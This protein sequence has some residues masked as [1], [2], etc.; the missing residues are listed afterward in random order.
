[1]KWWRTQFS[2]LTSSLVVVL[3]KH[4]VG[5]CLDLGREEIKACV[6]LLKSAETI[7]SSMPQMILRLQNPA[8]P[9][10]RQQLQRL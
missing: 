9:E 6:A 3:E 4:E 2:D 8:Y 1:M 7:H 5:Q 10:H